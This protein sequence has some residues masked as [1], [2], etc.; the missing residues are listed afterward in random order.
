MVG[1]LPPPVTATVDVLWSI[2]RRSEELDAES[3]AAGPAVLLLLEL[4]P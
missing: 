2:D 3:N 1:G 4:S